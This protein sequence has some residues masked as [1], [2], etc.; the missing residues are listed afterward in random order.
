MQR[1]LPLLAAFLSLAL[2]A[3]APAAAKET[4]AYIAIGD[5]LAFGVGATDP[6]TGGHVARTFDALRNSDRYS[7]R[8]LELVNLGVPGATSADLLLPGGQIDQALREIHDRQEDTSSSADN[9][10]VITVDIGGDGG[11]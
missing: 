5:S 1:L 2:L 7:D 4:P 10:E 6:A 9:V 11:A 3:P 8:G